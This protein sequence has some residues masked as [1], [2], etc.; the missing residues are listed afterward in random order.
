MYP[1]LFCWL[2]FAANGRNDCALFFQ[3]LHGFVNFFAVK[4]AKFGDF[5]G[6][7][8][9][10]GLLHSFQYFVFCFHNSKGFYVINIPRAKLRFSLFPLQIVN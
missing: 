9:F 2:P 7:Q 8:R 6:V 3:L 5:A 1:L 4:A 10:A